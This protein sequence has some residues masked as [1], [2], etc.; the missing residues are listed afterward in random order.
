MNKEVVAPIL[1]FTYKRLDVLKRTVTALQQNVLANGSNLFIFSDAA[2]TTEDE[3]LVSKVRH[4]IQTINGF[5]RIDIFEA[6]LNKGLANSIMSGV[7]QIINVYGNVIVLE[8]D[9]LT[10]PNFLL[11]MNLSLHFYQNIL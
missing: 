9:L 11:F 4:F 3:Q 6:S 2:K 10:S 8:D 5:K 1:L 7:T